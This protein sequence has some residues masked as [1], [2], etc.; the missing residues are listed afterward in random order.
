MKK[1]I[2]LLMSLLLATSA[3]A[4]VGCGEDD[5]DDNGGGTC[6]HIDEDKDGRCDKCGD[7]SNGYHG[8]EEENGGAL[9]YT[10]VDENGGE[11]EQGSYVLFGS[12]PQTA[13]TDEGVVT[14]LNAL[15]GDTPSNGSNG[16]WT[17][18]KY[19]AGSGELGKQSNETDYMWYQDITHEGVEY[20]GVYFN[21]W[22]PTSTC[23]SGSYANNT[24]QDENGY[25]SNT[26]YWFKYEPIL[27]EILGQTDTEATITTNMI[28]DSQEYNYTTK[29]QTVGESQIYSN[30]YAYSSIRTWLNEVFYETAFNELQQAII[31]TI[32]VDNSA[33]TTANTENA[34]AYEN[35][36]DKVWLLS[37]QEAN[38][39]FADD[40]ERGKTGSDYAKCQGLAVNTENG[41]SYYWLR[42]PHESGGARSVRDS[43]A[44]ATSASF[45]IET[46]YGVCPAIKINL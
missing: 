40:A 8:G 41:G 17:S 5:K 6:T 45:V 20:R 21:T 38:T 35:T 43:G 13:V 22:R 39:Y 30:V 32:T 36:Q 25:S 29:S 33:A 37:Y 7:L 26:V 27:W 9:Q 15:T 4:F 28:V 23:D 19:Y 42:S 46:D 1:T 34:Y 31:Q 44:L 3:F 24:E 18:Y 14:A 11:D 12:Y 16:A 10:R 2:C